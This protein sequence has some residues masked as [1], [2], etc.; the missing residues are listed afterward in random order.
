MNERNSD[1]DVLCPCS[2]G[3]Y[4]S[5]A[6]GDRLDMRKVLSVGMCSA[7]VCVFM[8]GCVSEWLHIYNKAYY[9]VFWILNGLLQ[10]SGWPAMVAV[11]G[12]WFGESR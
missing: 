9:I 12:N 7:A 8:F 4:I 1:L 2:Q 6:I 10:S 5:G 3:L 11:M